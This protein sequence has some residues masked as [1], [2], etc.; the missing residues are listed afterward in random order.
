MTARASSKRLLS[1]DDFLALP[2]TEPASELI[3]GE[4]VQKPLTRVK[5]NRV[6][7]RLARLLDAHPGT[8]DGEWL[9]EQSLVFRRAG[10]GNLRIPD[11][12][13]F[14]R[15]RLPANEDYP[16]EP[17]DLAVEVRSPGQTLAFLRRK[18]AFLR[19]Q[20]VDC[21]LLIDPDARTVEVHDGERFETHSG[22][23]TVTLASLGGFSFDVDQLFEAGPSA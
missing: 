10:R 14:A 15:D 17:P 20:G 7:R 1:L 4:V 19:E 3:D 9:P 22:S 23:G 18:L 5:H 6:T 13:F 2:E 11:L 12:V 16:D 21:T 8:A